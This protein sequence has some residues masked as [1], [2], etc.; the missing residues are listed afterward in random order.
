MNGWVTCAAMDG[1]AAAVSLAGTREVPPAVPP[2]L[3][4][5][6]AVN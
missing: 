3:V 6:V 5:V 4:G 1:N 2:D